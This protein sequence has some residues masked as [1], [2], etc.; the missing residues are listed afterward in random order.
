MQTSPLAQPHAQQVSDHQ[1]ADTDYYG[2]NDLRPMSFKRKVCVYT[3]LIIF[4]P[5]VLVLFIVY[6]LIVCCAMA[7]VSIN[8]HQLAT[9][10]VLGFEAWY[11]VPGQKLEVRETGGASSDIII[12]TDFVNREGMLDTCKSISL[13]KSI[14]CTVQKHC[15]EGVHGAKIERDEDRDQPHFLLHAWTDPFDP[16]T[17]EVWCTHARTATWAGLYSWTGQLP[18]GGWTSWDQA[19]NL[20]SAPDVFGY[21]YLFEI[22]NPEFYS[23]RSRVQRVSRGTVNA[24]DHT[25]ETDGKIFVRYGYQQVKYMGDFPDGDPDAYIFKGKVLQDAKLKILHTYRVMKPVL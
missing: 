7:I 11:K 18:A 5:I 16:E 14:E 17:D 12:S 15:S 21:I 20:E 9:G 22:S 4:S 23:S 2:R 1:S 19:I 8:G 25:K 24:P 13:R 6:L 10:K 3:A